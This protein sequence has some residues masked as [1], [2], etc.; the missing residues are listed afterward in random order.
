MSNK[1]FENFNAMMTQL[2][3]VPHNDIKANLDAEKAAKKDLKNHEEFH[4]KVYGNG[5]VAASA[6]RKL[7]NFSEREI[8]K[9][10]GIR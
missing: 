3:K 1:Q 10:T 7:S 6:L 2:V 5:R 9:G 4:C 8:N